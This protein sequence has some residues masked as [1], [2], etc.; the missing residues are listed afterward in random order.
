MMQGLQPLRPDERDLHLGAIIDIPKI[1]PDFILEGGWANGHIQEEDDCSAYAVT[2]ARE[3]REQV[4]LDREFSFAAMKSQTGDPESF[5]GDLRDA[6]SV[7]VKIGAIPLSQRPVSCI[8]KPLSFLRYIANWGTV[9][10]LTE[11]AWQR[12]AK[13]YVFV[14]PTQGMDAFDS[15]AGTMYYWMLKGEK[16][17][18][19]FGTY[20][21]WPL[22]DYVIDSWTGTGSGH[23]MSYIGKQTVNGVAYLVV[24]QNYGPSAGQNG[25]HL[26]SREVVNASEAIYGAGMFTSYTPDELRTMIVNGYKLDSSVGLPIIKA[27]LQFCLDLLAK[28]KNHVAGLFA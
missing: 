15:I 21:N 3:L 11:L 14:K 13:S 24:Q 5:G 18:V 12:R 23:A 9:A 4:E 6:L 2:L 17:A 26:F 10:T 16:R 28:L 1:V 8:G 20:W 7:P 19:P 27:L 22:N 25:R